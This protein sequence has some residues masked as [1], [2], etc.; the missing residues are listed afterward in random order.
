ML[1][2]SWAADTETPLTEQD[3]KN[4]NQIILVQPFW[5][6]AITPDG[7]PTRRQITVGNYKTQDGLRQGD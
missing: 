5:K 2:R 6:N 7:Q 4:L 3:I 1:F